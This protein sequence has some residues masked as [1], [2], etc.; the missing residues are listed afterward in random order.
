VALQGD[1]LLIK[2]R[3]YQNIGWGTEGPQVAFLPWREVLLARRLDKT[4]IT[5]GNEGD[6]REERRRYVEFE[7]GRGVALDELRGILANEREGRPGGLKMKTRWGHFPVSVEGD[8]T[9]R[10]EWRARVS[11]GRFMEDLRS[12]V[13]VDEPARATNDSS[14]TTVDDATL[15]ELARRGEVLPLITAIRRREDLSL[16]EAKQRA[17]AMIADGAHKG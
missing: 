15:G 17:E 7:L 12:W 13:A 5:R 16:T 2:W 14:R 9:I 6:P 10:V 4:W 1:G 8:R 11:I 3:S